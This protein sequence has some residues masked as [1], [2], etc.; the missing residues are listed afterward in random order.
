[1]R[2]LRWI[3]RECRLI[4]PTPCEFCWDNWSKKLTKKKS[5]LNKTYKWKICVQRGCG[6][7]ICIGF[8]LSSMAFDAG[9]QKV[10]IS[11]KQRMLK[12]WITFSEIWLHMLT[13]WDILKFKHF[14]NVTPIAWIDVQDLQLRPERSRSISSTVDLKATHHFG[15]RNTE[16]SKKVDD[17]AFHVRL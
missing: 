2:R 17:D 3:R 12:P 7:R 10:V 13:A 4:D 11:K 1:M 8:R 9:S 16:A 14:Y 15:G 6:C 5:R